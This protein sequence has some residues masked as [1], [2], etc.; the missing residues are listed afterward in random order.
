MNTSCA[1]SDNLPPFDAEAWLMAEIDLASRNTTDGEI[2]AAFVL[3]T[4]TS[5]PDASGAV[6]SIE[7]AAET[8]TES[9]L[10][11]CLTTFASRDQALSAMKSAA[12]HVFLIDVAPKT[13][14]LT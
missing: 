2:E 9:P 6:G 1:E 10:R 4:K 11:Y 12:D 13:E 3:V 5:L 8:S 14:D 7:I